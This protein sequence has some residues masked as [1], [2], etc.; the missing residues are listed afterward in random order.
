MPRRT[1]VPPPRPLVDWPAVRVALT[2]F[3]RRHWPEA[4][5]G[6][7]VFAL[8]C[9]Q[10]DPAG[11]W[12][13]APQGPGLTVDE[14]FNTQQGAF[15]SA[16]VRELGLAAV[17]P[18]AVRDVFATEG[19]LADHPPLG[20]LW[21]GVWHDL[22]WS[23][24]PP[25]DPGGP[26]CVACARVGSAA[27][28][29]LTVFLVSLCGTRWFGRVGGLGAGIA[30]VLMPRVFGHAH[31]AAL[32]TVTNLSFTASLLAVAAW[33]RP[34]ARIP[35][36]T[37]V[38]CGLL[39]GLALLTKIQGA[40]LGPAVAV[41]ALRWWGRRS[42]GSVAV[43]G[44]TGLAVFVFGWPWFWL[45]PGGHLAELGRFLFDRQP[46]RNFYLGRVWNTGLDDPTPWHYPFAMFAVTVP[47][48]LHALGV[49]GAA[50]GQAVPDI[51]EGSASKNLPRQAQ[52]DLRTRDPRTSLFLFATFVPLTICALRGGAMYDGA[53]LFLIAFP[54][55]A[56]LIGRG[57]SLLCSKVQS[58][59]AIST[60][61]SSHAG[62]YFGPAV[63]TLFL[64]TQSVGV[65]QMNPVW[66]SYYNASVGGL[67]GA[68]RLGFERNYWGDAVTRD[69]IT[70]A[71]RHFPPD[72]PLLLAPELHQFARQQWADASPAVRRRDT[73]EEAKLAFEWSESSDSKETSGG[74][75]VT[76]ADELGTIR[77]VRRA[78]WNG[79]VWDMGNY[80]LTYAFV[81]HTA[82]HLPAERSVRR[83][84]VVLAVATSASDEEV[85]LTGEEL[86]AAGW[87]EPEAWTDGGIYC[88]RD[89]EEF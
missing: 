21:L 47:I 5:L 82:R 27:A 60:V 84:G 61:R 2:R 86:K 43:F 12:P 64:L 28:F 49:W 50:V 58:S 89:D 63:L 87:V 14:G 16:A 25:V 23:V 38:G 4:L 71:D 77:F 33:W 13:G 83:Q 52:P 10:L 11:Q 78:Y 18:G 45:D 1:P 81:D 65:F 24:A 72:E 76:Y 19:Y 44:G 74:L 80:P 75:A 9:T 34:G 41:W 88:L 56:L 31:I 22:A 39:F 66:L 17:H 85:E 48:G 51:D 6:L 68:D 69:L 15:L 20:R 35:W 70:V 67:W 59:V 36:G 26:F 40:L 7:S 30:L 8:V 37:A 32:E 55:W 3:A 73:R 46:V 79:S 53:R 54:P 62:R 57:A 29:G 42:V